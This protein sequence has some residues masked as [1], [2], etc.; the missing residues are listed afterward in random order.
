MVPNNIIFKRIEAGVII[1]VLFGLFAALRAEE[2]TLLMPKQPPGATRILSFPSGQCTG[3]LYLEP[4]SGPGWDPEHVR[5]YG[6]WEYLNAAQG[7]VLVPEDRN[8]QPMVQNW[9]F[10]RQEA[11]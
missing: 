6:E 1:L 7:D 11:C 8:V 5:L 2:I 10:A 4:E 3:N 9:H